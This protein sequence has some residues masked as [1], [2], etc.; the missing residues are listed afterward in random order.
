[1]TRYNVWLD[2]LGLQDIDP[3][4]YITDIQEHAPAQLISTSAL[5][6]GSGM[7]VTRQNRQSLT[8]TV[9]FAIRAR[10]PVR[11]KTVMQAIRHWAGG[12]YLTL[13]DRTGQRLAVET[14]NL[15]AIQSALR[16][17]D[18]CSVSFTA[19]AVPFWEEASPVQ[20]SAASPVLTP[21]GDAP[22][23]PMDIR[24]R[25]TLSASA[26]TLT[27]TTPLSS[28]TFDNLPIASGQE[29]VITHEQG[30]LSATVSGADVLPFRTPDSSDDLL[31]AC[32]QANSV[33]IRVNGSA[34]QNY[35]LSARGRWL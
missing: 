3:A 15:P 12:R 19:Y 6:S 10:D 14:R 30:V 26:A 25:S 7:H 33:T 4:I 18:T 2:G 35:T 11:R 32:G 28:I 21:A 29:L 13:N 24:W 20:S 17:T 5:A 1:M 34:A 22:S 9:L 27:V 23:C 16:W 8:V 31:L